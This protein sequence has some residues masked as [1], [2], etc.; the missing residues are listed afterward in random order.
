MCKIIPPH[1]FQRGTGRPILSANLAV[2]RA[3]AG[4]RTELIDIDMA[5]PSAQLLFGRQDSELVHTINGYLLGWCA[6]EQTVHDLSRR[7][8]IHDEGRLFLIPSSADPGEIAP[9]TRR[10]FDVDQ[11][12]RAFQGLAASH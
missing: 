10:D 4:H 8:G 9:M 11:L 2:L 5:S 6:I 1:S 3:M 12:N 7:V